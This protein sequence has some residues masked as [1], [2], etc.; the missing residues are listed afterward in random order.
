MAAPEPQRN[1]KGA[2]V[3]EQGG[4]APLGL[5]AERLSREYQEVETAEVIKAIDNL[6]LQRDP[7]AAAIPAAIYKRIRAWVPYVREACNGVLRSGRYPKAIRRIHLIPL[8]K[9]GGNPQ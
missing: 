3:A 4:Y 6:S 2:V 5:L 9:I 7:G 1:R 8:L